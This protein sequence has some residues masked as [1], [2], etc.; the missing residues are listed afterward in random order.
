MAR[1]STESDVNREL[2]DLLRTNYPE[3]GDGISVE[4]TGMFED[5]TL[6]PDIL[7]YPPNGIPVVIET[8][9]SPA[10][11]AEIEAGNRLGR[12]L[13]NGPK[14]D[15]AVVLRLPANLQSAEQGS[16][17]ELIRSSRFKFCFLFKSRRGRPHE[18]L[19][20]EDWIEGD[21]DELVSYIETAAWLEGD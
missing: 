1:E 19:P 11:G 20:D 16:L 10:S 4:R 6:K 17:S 9:F 7:V 15:R 2:G 21:V 8:E 18:R 5:A 14:I 3:W 13:I 12:K